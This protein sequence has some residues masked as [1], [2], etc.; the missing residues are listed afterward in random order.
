MVGF[1]P[2]W[3]L[4]LQL[5]WIDWADAFKT[6]PVDL[7]NGSSAAVNGA[8]GSSAIQD[9]V[10]LNWRN[11]F[12]YRGGLQYEWCQIFFSGAAIVTAQALCPDKTLTPLTAAITEQT[13]TAGVGYQWSRYKID[14]AYQYDIPVTRNVGSSGL[15]SGEYSNSSI[16]VNLQWVVLT[17]GATF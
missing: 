9:N 12:V 15:L 14:L 13:V 5:D 17:I 1:H 3:R 7:S 4:A 10:P 11:E 8:A 16:A 2:Q 6:L